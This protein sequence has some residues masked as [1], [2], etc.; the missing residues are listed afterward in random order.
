[1]GLFENKQFAAGT[2]AVAKAVADATQAGAKSIIG[3]GDSVK[4]LPPGK[5]L[6]PP[7]SSPAPAHQAAR[8]VLAQGRQ[9]GAKLGATGK[10]VDQRAGMGQHVVGIGIFER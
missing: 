8:M 7:A 1:M 6:D 5:K 3:G 2:N 4:A 10:V 9:R